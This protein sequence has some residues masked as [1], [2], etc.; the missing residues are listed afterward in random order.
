MTK[1]KDIFT[2]KEDLTEL[3]NLIHK[4]SSSNSFK[5]RTKIEKALITVLRQMEVSGNRKRTMNDYRL[6]V[7]DFMKSEGLTF[8]DEIT[9]ESIYLWLEKMD[10]SSQTRLIRLKCLKAF[11]SRCFDNGWFETKFWKSINIKVDKQVKEG[12]TEQ[13]IKILLSVL[14]LKDFVQLR[15]ATAVLLMYK[16][17][18]RVS[19]LANLEENHIDLSDKL[20]RLNGD[21]LKSRESLLLPF[22]DV[23]TRMLDVLMKQNK[24][25]RCQYQKDNNFVF[26]TKQGG[27]IATGPSNNNIQKRLNKYAREYGLKNI[28][29]HSLR[30]GFAK[31]LLD[32][33]ARLTDI[34]KALGHSD[35]SVT[36][37]Y[38]YLDKNEVAENLREF[39]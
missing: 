15:D 21:I 3:A 23:L 8:L 22:D 24:A 9:T 31:S 28:N 37:Q 18:I 5:G 39:L 33:G 25:I 12:A 10:V 30:R 35:L 6:H 11:L 2:V 1:K 4:L 26:I 16:T 38:L 13:D 27:P 20:L 36:T 34:S 7:T 19:T 32:K 17:G 29:P 14:D